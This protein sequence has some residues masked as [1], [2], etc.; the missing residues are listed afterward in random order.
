MDYLR[1]CDHLWI[2]LLGQRD[3]LCRLLHLLLDV[4]VKNG[5]YSMHMWWILEQKMK[6]AFLYQSINVEMANNWQCSQNKIIIWLQKNLFLQKCL[7]NIL[8]M[9]SLWIYKQIY[10][11]NESEEKGW[12]TISKIINYKNGQIAENSFLLLKTTSFLN[13]GRIAFS[14]KKCNDISKFKSFSLSYC[15]AFNFFI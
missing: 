6:M 8:P 1:A 3:G 9:K 11:W 2:N 4:S 5:C 7:Q 15:L 13:L 12:T 10:K 14:K